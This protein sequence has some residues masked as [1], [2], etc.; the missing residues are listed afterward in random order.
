MPHLDRDFRDAL[1][2]AAGEARE[3][4][5]I[6]RDDPAVERKLRLEHIEAAIEFLQE[7][8][9]MLTPMTLAE[10]GYTVLEEVV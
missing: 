7:A 9:A 6:Y 2:D 4:D 10:R 8:R 3:A 1:A 5:R